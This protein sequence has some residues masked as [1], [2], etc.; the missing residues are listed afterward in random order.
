MINWGLVLVCAFG[1]G[2]WL[3]QKEGFRTGEEMGKAICILEL[4]QQAL[5]E[6]GCP[7]CSDTA[8]TTQGQNC[9]GGV[10]VV[11]W[12]EQSGEC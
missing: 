2:F 10:A 3:G 11:E 6:G 1:M 9:Q 12:T 4:K 8:A 5:H 7:I